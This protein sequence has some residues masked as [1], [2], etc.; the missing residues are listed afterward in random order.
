MP[1]SFEY[2]LAVRLGMGDFRDRDGD[3]FPNWYDVDSDNDT[4]KDSLEG[5][6]YYAEECASSVDC[7]AIKVQDACVSAIGCRFSLTCGCIKATCN[8][9]DASC[10]SSGITSRRFA[11]TKEERCKINTNDQGIP[12]YLDCAFPVSTACA[13]ESGE[14]VDDDVCVSRWPPSATSCA[15]VPVGGLIVF[16]CR[17]VLLGE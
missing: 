11:N 2:K 10:P 15:F 12:A 14:V 8:C 7:S 1:D 17:G 5:Y 6:P 16:A 9:G 4:V 13:Q 3:G